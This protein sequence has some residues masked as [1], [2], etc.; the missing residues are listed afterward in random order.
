MWH[1]VAPRYKL[2]QILRSPSRWCNKA[3]PHVAQN[4]PPPKGIGNGEFR[5]SKFEFQETLLELLGSGVRK[6]LKLLG[7]GVYYFGFRV[8][9]FDILDFVSNILGCQI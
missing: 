1:P 8:D 9:L 7:S 5:T 3:T 6:L 2:F 4:R